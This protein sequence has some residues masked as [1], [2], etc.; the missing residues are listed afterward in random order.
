MDTF[1]LFQEFRDQLQTSNLSARTIQKC[2]NLLYE[3]IDYHEELYD[4]L[5]QSLKDSV[6]SR[7]LQLF[8]LMDA[9]VKQSVKI[10]VFE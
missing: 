6:P 2:V 7:R 1:E 9:I 5:I 10:R 3:N 8:Y 4:A